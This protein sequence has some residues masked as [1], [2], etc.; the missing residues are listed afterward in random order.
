MTGKR[1]LPYKVR[2]SGADCFHLVLDKHAKKHGAGG[3]VMRKVFFFNSRID[4]KKIGQVLKR[5]DVINWL[6]NIRLR[7]PLF[8]IPYWQYTAGGK[9]I[10]LTQHD[11]PDEKQIPRSI[12]ERDITIKASRFVEADI[13][14]YPSGNSAFILSW[15]HILLDAKGTVLLFD[16]LNQLTEN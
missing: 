15:N 8:R 12:L 10:V 7:T 13:I 11:E 5:S 1:G 16:H 9:E 14:Y 6:C 2:L 4:H 3:N